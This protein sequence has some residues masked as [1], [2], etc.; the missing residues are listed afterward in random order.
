MLSK[1]KPRFLWLLL[2][3]KDCDFEYAFSIGTVRTCSEDFLPSQ[4]EEN[5]TKSHKVFLVCFLDGRQAGALKI[6]QRVYKCEE[7]HENT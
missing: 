1:T 7:S 2:E 6:F 4:S 3:K 5:V